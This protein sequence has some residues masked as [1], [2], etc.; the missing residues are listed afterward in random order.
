MKNIFLFLCVF[1]LVFVFYLTYSDSVSGICEICDEKNSISTYDEKINNQLE[2]VK[3]S[4]NKNPNELVYSYVNLPLDFTYGG[5]LI[6]LV[7]STLITTGDMLEL[8][9]GSFSTPVMHKIA[10]DFNR[11]IVSV[12]TDSK[13]MSKFLLYNQ[14]RSHKIY[15]LDKEES[16]MKFGLDKEWS[17]VLV[18]HYYPRL[19]PLNVINFANL[20]K[21]VVV[22]DTD[23]TR[24]HTYLYEKSQ[25]RS[26]YKYACKFSIFDGPSKRVYSSTTILSNYID[27]E[28]ELKPLFD[29]VKTTYGH[30]SCN[31]SM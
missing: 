16:L 11:R 29:R 15:L 10:T 13:W 9:V 20:S 24:E 31:L 2:Y 27:V 14:T 5:N 30:E 26:Y 18:D 1:V 22:H 3:S 28:S 4:L 8:G 17:V 19:R 25:M 21:I 7:I 23:K 12:D 6:P